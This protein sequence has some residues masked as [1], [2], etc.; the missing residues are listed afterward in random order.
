MPS[1]RHQMAVQL[2]R[3]QPRML[4]PSLATIRTFMDRFA[5]ILPVPAGVEIRSVRHAGLEGEWIEPAEGT[6]R[7]ILYLHGGGY[8]AGSIATHRALAARISV[9]CQAR[10]L[11]IA[12]RLAPGTAP[13]RLRFEHDLGT[14]G[15]V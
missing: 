1:F 11:V 10:V 14:I 4:H 2:V 12:Y 3:A 7:T 9:V 13:R 15:D 6:S 5:R 8:C